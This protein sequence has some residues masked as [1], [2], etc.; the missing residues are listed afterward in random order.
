MNVHGDNNTRGRSR[1]SG[2]R[3]GRHG[4]VT[5]MVAQAGIGRI[6][7]IKT[8]SGRPGGSVANNRVIARRCAVACVRRE[9]GM[10]VVSQTGGTRTTGRQ[11]KCRPPSYGS[12]A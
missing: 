2:E 3:P 1:L 9:A 4:G 11:T 5:G 12:V 10:R 6:V 7:V 8:G